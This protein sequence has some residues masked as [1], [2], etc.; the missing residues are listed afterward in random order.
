MTT[1]PQ[2]GSIEAV[3]QML[4]EQP[5]QAEINQGEAV[6]AETETPVGE[7]IDVEEYI[8]E[9]QD[10]EDID[11]I[12]DFDDVELEDELAVETA[13]PLEL[14][15]DLSLE[16]KSNGEMKKVTLKE[17]KQSFAGQDY[18]QK[19]MADNAELK[20]Q[21][22]AD[23]QAQAE[24]N[25]RLDA[26]INQ[27]ENGTAPQKPSK[28]SQELANSDPLDYAI[29]LGEYRE[30]MAEYEAHRAELS[31]AQ[32]IAA[33]QR[34]AEQQ[35]YANQQAELLK[36]EIPELNDPEKG[37]VL[38]SEIQKTATEHYGVP[39]EI[40]K[41][42]V[43][44][45]EFKILKDAAAYQRLKQKRQKVAEKTKDARPMVKP[46]AKRTEDP[47]AKKAQAATRNMRK[48]GTQSDVVNWLLS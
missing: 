1:E 6:E 45:W 17:L 29:R 5:P 37:K 43:H 44:G 8:A 4:M 14:S 9:S 2:S 39:P 21:L 13:A 36:Q 30:Q 35:R 48:R 42:L 41:N 24:R 26:I 15:D 47:K 32:S 7:Q 18:I 40:L 33:K 25:A 46:G 22:E 11:L 28:P 31:E 34:E 19:G 23:V 3:A 27:Y 12:E 20:K 38:L 10:D 16:V